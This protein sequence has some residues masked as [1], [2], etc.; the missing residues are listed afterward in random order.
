MTKDKTRRCY[1]CNK[2]IEVDC[3]YYDY[4]LCKCDNIGKTYV[5][6]DACEDC[7]K[8]I[9]QMIRDKFKNP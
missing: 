3:W 2:E 6:F 7:L 1:F 5:D 8:D 9:V 4:C